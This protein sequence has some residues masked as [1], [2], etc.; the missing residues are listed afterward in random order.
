MINYPGFS[1]TEK[2]SGTFRAKTRKLLS[3]SGP[4]SH[5]N[6]PPQQYKDHRITK[7]SN[8]MGEAQNIMLSE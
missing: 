3:K 8:N 2:F 5:S 4:V 6:Y 1:G 7:T